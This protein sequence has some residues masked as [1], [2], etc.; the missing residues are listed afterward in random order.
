MC[1][2]HEQNSDSGCGAFS[3]RNAKT[4]AACDDH[5]P[6]LD[7][8]VVTE[9][10]LKRA[11]SELYEIQAQLL[12]V[13]RAERKALM[14]RSSELDATINRLQKDF[15]HS[16]AIMAAATSLS[17]SIA[18]EDADEIAAS[19]E[20]LVTTAADITCVDDITLCYLISVGD[21]VVDAMKRHKEHH[22]VVKGACHA[23]CSLFSGLKSLDNGDAI[24]E[25]L[26]SHDMGDIVIQGMAHHITDRD[27]QLYGCRVLNILAVTMN[28]QD[29]SIEDCV[30][31]ACFFASAR[32]AV[33]KARRQH[34]TDKD[35]TQWADCAMRLI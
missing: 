21:S 26:C 13:P 8:A 19:L 28:P 27:V 1:L 35:V 18:A 29:D 10:L 25:Q 7:S 33:A 31:T 23:L 12:S 11:N 20:R 24:A 9:D 22:G 32:I 2:S 3:P 6:E 30:A 16:N 34:P 15:A 4:T 17:D 14:A 5:S